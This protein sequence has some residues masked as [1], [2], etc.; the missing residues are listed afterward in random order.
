M[1]RSEKKCVVVWGP[2]QAL[3]PYDDYMGR[4]IDRGGWR[5]VL[6]Q[7]LVDNRE[8]IRQRLLHDLDTRLKSLDLQRIPYQGSGDDFQMALSHQLTNGEKESLV[9]LMTT[10]H[11]TDKTIKEVVMR[12]ATLQEVAQF[13]RRSVQVIM[14]AEEEDV[15]IKPNN[16]N[17]GAPPITM[18]FDGVSCYHGCTT[19][20]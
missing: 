14:P 2:P 5:T 16:G 4:E 17:P 1:V 19:L 3:M 7:Q 18:C 11:P 6:G 13:F 12:V 9:G 20:Q 8:M 15:E 10:S